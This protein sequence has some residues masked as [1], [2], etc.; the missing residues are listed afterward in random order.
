[1]TLMM[2]TSTIMEVILP[3]PTTIAINEGE[4]HH[5]IN[6]PQLHQVLL[7][8]TYPH[9]SHILSHIL[10]HTITFSHPV[11]VSM[12]VVTLVFFIMWDASKTKLAT[13]SSVN[14]PQ[15][16]ALQLT[17]SDPYLIDSQGC[18]HSVPPKDPLPH[19]VV[20]PAG[21]VSK[22]H[23]YHIYVVSSLLTSYESFSVNR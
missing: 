23:L 4:V 20:P 19:I 9:S 1:M 11:M 7:T 16:P 8:T 13:D 12:V 3:T 14:L 10:S 21:P 5:V 22:C 6:G 2:T 15:Q 18:Y 17:P